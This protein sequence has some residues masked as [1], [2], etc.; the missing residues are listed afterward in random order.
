MAQ[1]TSIPKKFRNKEFTFIN[2]LANGKEEDRTLKLFPK[3]V[4]FA[5][6]AQDEEVILVV[7]RH[8]I[9]YLAH[10]LLALIVL[11]VPLVLLLVTH[12]I[13]DTYGGTTLYLGLFVVSVVISANILVTAFMQ[14]YYNVSIITDKKIVALTVAN[15][16]QHD[17][18]E[19]LWRKVQDVSHD[20][21]GPLSSMLDLGNMYIDTAGE[22]VDLTLTFVPC[23]RDVQ[24]VIDNLV[25][26]THKGKL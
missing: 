15:V 4:G 16:F 12:K 25:E 21:V 10:V 7:R 23:P 2:N 6:K 14:W 3:N 1:K 8:W 18:I 26:L 9:A 20:S 5:R 22:G 24:D 19:I 17:Y 11:I 13:S